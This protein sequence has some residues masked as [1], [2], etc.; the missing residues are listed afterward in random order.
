MQR[1]LQVNFDAWDKL[2]GDT[3]ASI[4][5]YL[6]SHFKHGTL[7]EKTVARTIA[8]SAE[9]ASFK[10]NSSGKTFP[11]F[12]AMF[13]HDFLAVE[14]EA[15]KTYYLISRIDHKT[16][17]SVTF[18]AQAALVCKNDW[19][20]LE[21]RELKKMLVTKKL[22]V[23]NLRDE[24]SLLL[25][26]ALTAESTKLFWER[27]RT[28]KVVLKDEAT[29]AFFSLSNDLQKRLSGL[30]PNDHAYEVMPEKEKA[31]GR[32]SKAYP[33]VSV[34]KPTF[35]GRLQKKPSNRIVKHT[36]ILGQKPALALKQE[37]VYQAVKHLS[38]KKTLII[39]SEKETIWVGVEEN[40]C[41]QEG[42]DLYLEKHLYS[43]L[44]LVQLALAI[45]EACYEQT[46]LYGLVHRDI[47]W[48]NLFIAG[49][50]HWVVN[51][52]DYDSAKFINTVDDTVEGT[53]Y[54]MAREAIFRDSRTESDIFSMG[55]LLATLFDGHFEAVDETQMLIFAS[56][57]KV[58]GVFS[59]P[60][61]PDVI[62]N[63]IGPL[64]KSIINPCW[65][66]R[67]SYPQIITEFDNA[68]LDMFLEEKNLPENEVRLLA[69]EAILLRDKIRYGGLEKKYEVL[70]ALTSSFPTEKKACD[71]FKAFLRVNAAWEKIDLTMLKQDYQNW[72][73]KIENNPLQKLS[74]EL[75]A[76]LPQLSH[77]S[78]E[79]AREYEHQGRDMQACLKS[80]ITDPRYYPTKFDEIE[81]RYEQLCHWG[82]K[83]SDLINAVKRVLSVSD[84]R[85]SRVQGI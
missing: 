32:H 76:L 78:S 44:S 42:Y 43:K 11:E 64:L 74:A 53:I 13:S 61:W 33:S 35:F 1:I 82:E 30:N 39:N 3:L 7:F 55:V 41:G 34:L 28:Q 56:N 2:D 59:N 63:R 18:H 26:H 66:E 15:E 17:W 54:Y 57:P 47:K 27:E 60:E 21:E 10:K 72:V 36:K 4:Q 22:N 80:L 68:L 19:W 58:K 8:S 85:L 70:R 73:N 46:V 25:Q 12:A 29:T 49:E 24:Q 6:S 38:R 48:D 45:V 23:Q 31:F 79:R 75:A 5:V 20:H 50:G 51:L 9:E 16:D 37:A 65:K 67:P 52:I 71:I 83:A 62:R 14:Y 40:Q 84:H 69:K 81:K 77:H